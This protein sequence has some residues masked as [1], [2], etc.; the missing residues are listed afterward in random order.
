MH[1][2]CQTRH[3]KRAEAKQKASLI[4]ILMNRAFPILQ[5]LEKDWSPC[6]IQLDNLMYTLF[7]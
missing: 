6:H 5:P 7:W 2:R 3:A 1:R 4:A